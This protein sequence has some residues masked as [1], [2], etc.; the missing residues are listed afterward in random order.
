VDER[1]KPNLRGIV[2]AIT[3]VKNLL[4]I[5]LPTA[6]FLFVTF[7]ILGALIGAGITMLLYPYTPRFKRQAEKAKTKMGMG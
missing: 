7:F 1:G 6:E 4:Y 3:M 5:D 2:K